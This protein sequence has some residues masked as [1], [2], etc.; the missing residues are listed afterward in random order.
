MLGLTKTVAK[1]YASR[2]ITCNAIAPG[3]I[4]SDMTAA[5]D[6]KYE[7]AILKQIPLGEPYLYHRIRLDG[8]HS[9]AQFFPMVVPSSEVHLPALERELITRMPRYTTATEFA[10]ELFTYSL[11]WASLIFM[12]Q[13][14]MLEIYIT[15]AIRW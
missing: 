2:S 12:T 14:E 13:S 9:D 4:K 8:M 5:I 1:E 15:P 7:E 6:P 3:F 10:D 11:L